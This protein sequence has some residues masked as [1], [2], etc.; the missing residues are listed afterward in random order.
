[1]NE[2]F[3]I[4]GLRVIPSQDYLLTEWNPARGGA[5]IRVYGTAAGRFYQ[6]K[7]DLVDTE[8]CFI[9]A[10]Q[11]REF[12]HKHPAGTDAAAYTALFGE[13]ERG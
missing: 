6:V 8:V 13:P 3:I 9:P 1:M 4:D 5:A 12:A 10:H 2:V 11:A 7:N